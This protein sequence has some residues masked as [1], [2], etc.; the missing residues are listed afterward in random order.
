MRI[1]PGLLTRYG[2]PAHSSSSFMDDLTG[3]P[4][5]RYLLHALDSLI[6]LDQQ[7]SLLFLDMDGFKRVN[8][9]MGH[10][11]GDTVLERVGEILVSRVRFD[12][13]PVR[14]GGDEFV[15]L[16]P[17]TDSG[18]RVG[19]RLL[20]AFNNTLKPRWGVTAS[21]GEALYPLHG[22]LAGDVLRAADR[23]MYRAKS[24]G[25]N[26]MRRAQESGEALFWHDDVFVGREDELDLILKAHA[27]P[28]NTGLLL[29]GDAGSGKTLLLERAAARFPS[30]T[31]CRI[32]GRPELSGISWAPLLPWV[33]GLVSAFDAL[34][35]AS[36]SRVLCGVF[37]GVFPES[38]LQLVRPDS[39]AVLEALSALVSTRLPTAFL[40]DNAQWLDPGTASFLGYALR[41]GIPSGLSLVVATRSDALEALSVLFPGSEQFRRLHLKPFN[42]DQ[43][44][45]LVRARL[46][47]SKPLRELSVKAFRFS[48]GNP[49]FA[50]EFLRAGCS[51]DGEFSGEGLPGEGPL[52]SIPERVEGIVK[53]RL[54]ALPGECLTV[55]QHASAERRGNPDPVSLV[56]STGLTE[57]EVLGFLDDAVKAGVLAPGRE[58]LLSYRFPNEA[59]RLAV[60]SS[61]PQSVL[62][63]AHSALAAMHRR[64]GD[65]LEAGHHLEMIGSH[66]QAYLN[67]RE[68]SDA[69]LTTWL[70]GVGVACLER[71][72]SQAG[73]LVATG[74][75]APGEVFDLDTELIRSQVNCGYWEKVRKTALE[76]ADYAVAHGVPERAPAHRL[77]AADSLR[78]QGKSFDAVHE[79]ERILP[80]TTGNDR[81][82]T[83]IKLADSLSRACRAPEALDRLTE[84]EA[85]LD[86]TFPR[87]SEFLVHIAHKKLFCAIALNMP[88]MGYRACREM[89]KHRVG[90]FTF[91]WYFIHDI[92]EFHLLSGQPLTALKHLTEAEHLAQEEASFYGTTCSRALGVDAQYHSFQYRW[93]ELGI[94]EVGNSAK[95][96]DDSEFIREMDLIRCRMLLDSGHVE[97]A[98]EALKGPLQKRPDCPAALYTNSLILE[99]TG[100]FGGSLNSIERALRTV[101]G[102]CLAPI[103]INSISITRDELDLQRTW[104]EIRLC[105]PPDAAETLR[106][107]M[108][109]GS[110][111]ASFRAAGLLA[112]KLHGTG[113]TQEADAVLTEACAREDWFEMLRQ[114]HENLAIGA[115]WNDGFRREAQRMQ[116][117]A[118]GGGSPASEAPGKEA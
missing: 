47:S 93:V 42:R 96:L 95:R 92:G 30:G 16:V 55:L 36:W 98:A 49:L 56:A 115:A 48:G 70:P 68:G 91:H 26:C 107:R 27:S 58:V 81:I 12:D 79:L 9:T 23:A 44:G 101:G 67:Y 31:V 40:V 10:E 90:D 110:P 38:P 97:L 20:E 114:R 111:R 62:I 118:S 2:I 8:D 25:G 60:Y 13:R 86:Q 34:P 112:F 100:D 76:A 4:N 41:V 99:R 28:E 18:N 116:R 102:T 73:G 53:N 5:R 64:N 71:A 32:E 1:S 108:L 52:S 117:E 24:A 104:M 83:L 109:C 80:S 63:A 39:L 82:D 75:V 7:F 84:A 17:G 94:S 15:V 72:R 87:H 105:N 57:G 33:R 89:L 113:L 43:V 61:A 65:F 6:T 88:G 29:T 46:G 74:Q 14:F 35:E 66:F 78:V 69:N 50:C 106:E 103:S 85:L 11:E 59:V 51:Q 77:L 19:E 21:I 45:E 54:L 22:P 3:L 37:P